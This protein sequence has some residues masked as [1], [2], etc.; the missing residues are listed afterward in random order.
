[1]K[2]GLVNHQRLTKNTLVLFL[3]MMIVAAIGLYTSRVVL[4]VLGVSDYGIYQVVSGL[5]TIAA[6][7][8]WVLNGTTQRFLNIAMGRQQPE[9]LK[10]VFSSAIVIQLLLTA[11][12]L[13]LAETIGLWFLN[14]CVNIPEGRMAAANWVYQFAVVAF[15]VDLMSSPYDAAVIAHERMS[16]FA[17]LGI[18]RSVLNLMIAISLLYVAQDRLVVCAFLGLLVSMA[19]RYVYVVYCR[20]HFS[21]CVFHRVSVCKDTVRKMA[22]FAFW[23]QFG[24]LGYAL[25]QKG[26]L[27]LVNL[28]FGVTVNAALGIAFI[29]YSQVR[30]FMANFMTALKPQIVTCYAAGDRGELHLLICRSSRIAFCMVLLVMVPILM[31]T[32]ELL[33]FWL[34]EVPPYTVVFVRI[35]LATILADSFSMVMEIANAATGHVKDYGLWIAFLAVA[36]LLLTVLFFLLGYESEYALYIYLLAILAEQ[37]IR[38]RIVCRDTGLPTRQFLRDMT[39][40]ML[41]TAVAAFALPILLSTML[42]EGWQMTFLK[43]VAGVAWT[44]LCAWMLSFTTQERKSILIT[45]RSRIQR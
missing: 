43:I 44:A 11:C 4:Q 38:T 6:F 15:I 22:R 35:I 17:G 33:G 26:M 40:Y 14:D 10:R 27:L 30:R 18:V 23:S 25:H 16:A 39:R 37:V 3:R 31:E 1:M 2:Q 36:H 13:L 7:L 12:V 21:E 8:Q 41:P 29:V 20:K 42:G 28:F 45:L 34:K 5:V 24:H 32:P 9:E 19:L